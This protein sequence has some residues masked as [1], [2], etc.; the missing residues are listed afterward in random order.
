MDILVE[1][2]AFRQHS[3]FHPSGARRNPQK[4]SGSRELFIPDSIYVL[5][6][7]AVGKGKYT[8]NSRKTGARTDGPAQHRRT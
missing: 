4:A 2:E 7:S 3:S 6:F 1:G 8:A 5:F